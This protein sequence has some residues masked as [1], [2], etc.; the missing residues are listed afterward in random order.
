MNK[1]GEG[2][3][4]RGQRLR[5]RERFTHILTTIDFPPLDDDE[6]PQRT[7][8]EGHL[9]VKDSPLSLNFERKEETGDSCRGAD[10]FFGRGV[11]MW[12]RR[13][14]RR[15]AEPIVLWNV[16]RSL[17]PPSSFNTIDSHTP[18]KVLSIN[19]ISFPL[20]NYDD[21]FYS[22]QHGGRKFAPL[23]HTYI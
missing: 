2:R 19:G 5:R 21:T 18:G 8:D 11:K 16:F 14:N 20:E 17:W 15:R 23:T 9:Y 22:L 7:A 12:V 3:P 4:K 10:F 1:G 13:V 6:A